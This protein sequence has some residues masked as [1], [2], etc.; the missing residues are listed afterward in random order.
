M[1]L[2]GLLG[3]MSWQSTETYYRLINEGIG[4]ALGGLHS[5]RLI[6]SSIDFAPLEAMQANGDWDAAGELLANEAKRLETAG[7]E[8][9]VLCTNT[10]HNVA[11]KIEQSIDIPLLHIADATGEKLQAEDVNTVALLGTRFT[12]EQDFYKARLVDRYGL[13]V[14]VPE[15]TDRQAVHDII[16]QELCHGVIQEKSRQ[17][18]LEIIGDLSA[19]GAQCVILGCTEIGLLVKQRD[20]DVLLLDTTA[21]H[22]ASAVSFLLATA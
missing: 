9:I 6:L 21:I 20:T 3:G 14:M 5:A 16:Y 7:A 18:Y 8:G 2:L 1:R 15:Q 22:A 17:R 19:R 11:E 4:A 13:D 10:M 12:M